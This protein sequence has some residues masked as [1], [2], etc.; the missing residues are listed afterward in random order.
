MFVFSVVVRSCTC[1]RVS[2]KPFQRTVLTLLTLT[3]S[4]ARH[5]LASMDITRTVADLN[6]LNDL[7]EAQCVAGIDKDESLDALFTS[8]KLRLGMFKDIQPKSALLVTK[9]IN[10]GPWSGEHGSC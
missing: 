9:A 10:G 1:A 4:V 3:L 7:V 5:I 8:W 2:V 6:D